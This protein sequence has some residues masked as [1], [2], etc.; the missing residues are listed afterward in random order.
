MGQYSE[1]IRGKMIR[2]TKR[3]EKGVAYAAIADL[4][5]KSKQEI[6]GSQEILQG[7]YAIFQKLADYEDAGLE[8]TEVKKLITEKEKN[9]E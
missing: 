8:P 3:N 4:L 7:I 1:I 6:E 5:P 2:L 9:N